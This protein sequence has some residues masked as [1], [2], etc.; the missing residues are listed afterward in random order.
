[1]TGGSGVH[2]E[3]SYLTLLTG[4]DSWAWGRK[5]GRMGAAPGSPRPST[6]PKGTLHTPGSCFLTDTPWLLLLPGPHWV[7]EAQRQ[8]WGSLFALGNSSAH[9][10][11]RHPSLLTLP[12]RGS[13]E[14]EDT[15][16]REGP[17]QSTSQPGSQ[18]LSKDG[19]ARSLSHEPPDGP[20]L[21]WL[22]LE[23]DLALGQ[24]YPVVAQALPLMVPI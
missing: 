20:N 19:G 4:P 12:W 9:T 24:T 16:G 8:T 21:C 23:R 7:R 1:M 10:S 13:W 22:R 2:G 11:P 3:I 17:L 18:A 5:P 6:D 14:R 15:P